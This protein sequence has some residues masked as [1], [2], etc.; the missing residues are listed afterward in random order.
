MGDFFFFLTLSGLSFPINVR[1]G[2]EASRR[3]GE[4][5]NIAPPRI[6]LILTQLDLSKNFWYE[7]YIMHYVRFVDL[8]QIF[9]IVRTLTGSRKT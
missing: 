9:K 8:T 5:G 2:G 4:G 7:I 6:C 3:G 1:P